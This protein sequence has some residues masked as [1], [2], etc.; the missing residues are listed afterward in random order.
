MPSP[1]AI[2]YPWK[3]WR[4]V[5]RGGQ[6]CRFCRFSI[7]HRP[8]SSRI[9]D[10]KGVC[11]NRRRQWRGKNGKDGSGIGN[12]GNEI[13]KVETQSRPNMDGEWTA[14]GISGC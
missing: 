8:V 5:K 2:L 3:R 9:P 14:S 12:G 13:G 10:F 11:R 4:K 1:Q 7:A 6:H